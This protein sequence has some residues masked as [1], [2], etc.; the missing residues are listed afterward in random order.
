[1]GTV[2]DAGSAEGAQDVI[3]EVLKYNCTEPLEA[4]TVMSWE[5]IA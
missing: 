3:V 5:N 4:L 2:T 1:M